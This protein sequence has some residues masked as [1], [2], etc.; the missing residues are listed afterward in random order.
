[1]R[2]PMAVASW[3]MEGTMD[4]VARELG[5][6]PLEV[7]RRNSHHRGRPALA[8]RDRRALRR[9]DAARHAGRGRGGDRLRGT[10][11]GSGAAGQ[12][13]RPRPLHRGGEHDLWLRLLPSPPASPGSGHEVATIRVEPSGIAI[14]SCGLMGSGQ[15]YETTL[16][17]AA[18]AGLGAAFDDVA[19]ADRQQR[20]RALWHGQPRQPGCRGGRRRAL[21]GGAAAEGEGAG[22]R[23]GDARPEQRRRARAA[24]GQGAA[25]RRGRLGGDGADSGAAGARRASRSAA[26]AAGDGA[27]PARGARLRPAGDDLFQQHACLRGGDRPRD[28]RADHPAPRHRR[29]FRH[30][31]SIRWWWMASSMARPRWACRAP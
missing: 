30:A 11:R 15:G 31:A 25:P 22:D 5:L 20:H 27:G 9:A 18:A 7:R 24:R 16:A 29:G 12:A 13:A 6:D 21:H 10:A 1:M 4:A 8:H 28:G 14:A 3:V 23:R 17:Q 26:P 2:A 19:G